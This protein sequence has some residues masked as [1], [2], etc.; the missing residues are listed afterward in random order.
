[1]LQTSSQGSEFSDLWSAFSRSGSQAEYCQRWLDLQCARI[2]YAK[3]AILLLRTEQHS[4]SNFT[5]IGQWPENGEALSA[6]VELADRVIEEQ[7]GLVSDLD[8]QVTVDDIQVDLY[9]VA[10]P[11][12]VDQQIAGVVAVAIATRAESALA[13][14]MEQ[15]QWGISWVELLVRRHQRSQ[16]DSELPRLRSALEVLT[17]VLADDSFDASSMTFVTGLASALGCERVSFGVMRLGRIRIKAISNSAEFGKQMNLVKLVE[18]AMEEAVFQRGD[19]TFPA[20]DES[21]L[22][23]RDHTHLAEKHGCG[24]IYT[25]PLFQ[26]EHYFGAVTLE[27]TGE[28]PFHVDELAAARAI[29]ALCGEALQLKQ[30]NDR[31]LH[32]K[33]GE[34]LYNQA[35][36][37]LGPGYLGRKL[38]LLMIAVLVVFFSLATDTY[39]VAADTRLEGA[40]RQ[41]VVAPFDG[42]I[43]SADAR[44]GDQVVREQL[45]SRLDDRDL[46]LERLHW[47]GERAKLQRQYEEA[48]ATHDRAKSKVLA[49]QLEQNQANLDLVERQLQRTALRAPFDGLV[50]NGDLTQLI[51]SAVKQ[52]DV[53]FEVAPLDAYR[54]IMWVDEH[55]IGEIAEGMAGRMVLKAMPEE[56]FGLRIS[57]ITPITEAR[58]GGNFFRVE[59][60]L[61]GTSPRLRPGME[62]VAKIEIGERNLFFTLTRDLARWVRLKAWAWTP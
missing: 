4:A 56:R 60:V 51:G 49:A 9:G 1:M 12:K 32:S 58:D 59:A 52:G 17:S 5:P 41:A 11:L 24:A 21:A 33:V 36:R 19:I 8:Q 22:V 10:Y 29:T 14:A 44:A 31:P 28:R 61:E 6:I 62:G 18:A 42:Y 13:Y 20:S 39:R 15:L 38:A 30:R 34:S 7:C 55:Q 50:I 43:D 37:L 27:R 47:V 40:V 16:L 35:R 54:V 2:P 26:D 25:L 53:L 45:L 23:V 46:R 3:N 48:L 57:R